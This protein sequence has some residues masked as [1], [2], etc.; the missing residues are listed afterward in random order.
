MVADDHPIVR[1]GVVA[2]LK[3]QR[4]LKVIGEANDGAEVLEFIKGESLTAKFI[5]RPK[6]RRNSWTG[7]KNLSSVQG[8]WRF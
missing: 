2:N 5:C 8:N 1:E 3:R 7:C 6:S 4:D